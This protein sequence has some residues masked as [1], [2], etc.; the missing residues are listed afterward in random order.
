M[1]QQALS[2]VLSLIHGKVIVEHCCRQELYREKLFQ[3]HCS[4]HLDIGLELGWKIFLH[5]CSQSGLCMLRVMFRQNLLCVVELSGDFVTTTHET[6]MTHC[7]DVLHY[8]VSMLTL[9]LLSL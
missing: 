2:L 6:C 3:P 8:P 4:V 5:I 1:L 9:M 7:P